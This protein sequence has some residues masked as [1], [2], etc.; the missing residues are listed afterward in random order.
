MMIEDVHIT[1][2]SKF[3]LAWKAKDF[4]VGTLLQVPLTKLFSSMATLWAQ[5]L[6]LLH[7]VGL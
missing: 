6:H 5:A 3:F 7:V 4:F 1:L 2:T